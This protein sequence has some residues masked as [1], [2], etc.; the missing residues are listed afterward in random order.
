MCSLANE[1]LTIYI[2][3]LG[4]AT[5]VYVTCALEVIAL[6]FLWVALNKSEALMKE[7]YKAVLF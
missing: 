7:Q 6:I 4:L 2:I 3:W 1:Q 5:F